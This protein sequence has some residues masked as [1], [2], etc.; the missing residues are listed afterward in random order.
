[1]F[2]SQ[3]FSGSSSSRPSTFAT[4]NV[5]CDSQAVHLKEDQT[6]KNTGMAKNIESER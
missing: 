6:H 2:D 5:H 1:M 3:T 4:E